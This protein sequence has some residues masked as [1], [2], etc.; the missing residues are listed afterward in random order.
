MQL[1]YFWQSSNLHRAWDSGIIDNQQ[2]S[3]TEYVEW[4]DHASESQKEEW[5]SLNVLDWANESKEYRKQCYETLPE[6]M[7]L[8][9]RYNFDNIDLVNQ[10]LLQAGLRLAGVLNKIYG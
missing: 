3:Y 7:K 6:N 10:R 5:K 2:Y 1:E 4:I 8:N 9:Y